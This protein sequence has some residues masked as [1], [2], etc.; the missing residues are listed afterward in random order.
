M[1]CRPPH[2]V[3]QVV[4]ACRDAMSFHSIVG[5][6]K[7]SSTTKGF[8]TSHPSAAFSLANCPRL[9]T[10]NKLPPHCP[11]SSVVAHFA[12]WGLSS[13]EVMAFQRFQT[14]EQDWP[15]VPKACCRDG[16]ASC[17]NLEAA[18]LTAHAALS[19]PSSFAGKW[20]RT[21]FSK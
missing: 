3:N 16:Q 5:S 4:G 8:H 18:I 15:W 7:V 1:P 12:R 6:S 2:H 20:P 9:N 21:Q 19:L 17:G 14:S 10:A 11:P 13:S